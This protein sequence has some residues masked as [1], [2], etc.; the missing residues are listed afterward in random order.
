MRSSLPCEAIEQ[1]KATCGALVFAPRPVRELEEDGDAPAARVPGYRLPPLSTNGGPAQPFDEIFRIMASFTA[2]NTASNTASS[3]APDETVVPGS[4]GVKRK[5]GEFSGGKEEDQSHAVSAVAEEGMGGAMKMGAAEAVVDDEGHTENDA[6][7]SSLG[8]SIGDSLDG[9][10][11]VTIQGIIRVSKCHTFINPSPE[12][13]HAR[14]PVVNNARNSLHTHTRSRTQTHMHIYIP[15]ARRRALRSGRLPCSKHG[16]C[17]VATDPPT[18]GLRPRTSNLRAPAYPCP[19]PSTHIVPSIYPPHCTNQ[20]TPGNIAAIVPGNNALLNDPKVARRVALQYLAKPMVEKGEVL[21]FDENLHQLVIP[22]TPFKPGTTDH[23][24]D[25]GPHITV[26][27]ATNRGRSSL[28]QLIRCVCAARYYSLIWLRAAYLW[29]HSRAGCYSGPTRIRSNIRVGDRGGHGARWEG[30]TLSYWPTA[31]NDIASIVTRMLQETG[32]YILVTV[33]PTPRR[34]QVTIS[35]KN[36]ML[37][38]G[39]AHNDE[40]C[41][42][43]YYLALQTDDTTGT[44]RRCARTHAL[45]LLHLAHPHAPT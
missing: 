8:D 41:G 14:G 13:T 7:A 26:R 15:R 25:K 29:T 45:R 1:N 20:V 22:R 38:E 42:C 36:P 9:S 34:F 40:A 35:F 37:L 32:A 21:G 12:S 24:P 6:D 31:W 33:P 19:M 44:A 10:S 5:Q 3:A 43:V 27:P 16:P 17:Y 30:G 18:K 4:G 2:S 11:V 23:W 28:L 39:H